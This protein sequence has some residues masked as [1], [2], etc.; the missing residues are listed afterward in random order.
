MAFALKKKQR[1]LA[2]PLDSFSD[3][4]FLLIIFFILTTQIQKMTGITTELPSGE[5]QTEQKQAQKTPTVA[6]HGGTIRLNESSMS[7]GQLA[8]E[9][10]GM[11]L[12]AKEPAQRVVLLESAKDVDYQRYFEVM[13]AITAANGVIGIMTEDK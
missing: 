12:G 4:A 2:L 5:K 3:I 7:L 11:N 1:D 10:K 13:A 9:L 6:L 8:A